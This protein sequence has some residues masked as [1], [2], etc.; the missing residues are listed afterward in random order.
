M[1]ARWK[2]GLNPDDLIARIEAGRRVTDGEITFEGWDLLNNE[3]LLLKMVDFREGVPQQEA[4]NIVQRALFKAGKKGELSR[5]TIISEINKEVNIYFQQPL[6]RFVL[7]TSLSINGNRLLPRMRFGTDQIIF[8]KLPPKFESES[9]RLKANISPVLQVIQPKD[10]MPVR[11]YLS[12]RSV[13]DA[14]NIALDRIDMIRGIWNWSINYD[15]GLRITFTGSPKPINKIILGPIHTIHRPS[16]QLCLNTNWLFEPSYIA[17]IPLYDISQKFEFIIKNTKSV[18]KKLSQ[19]Q[20]SDDII[21]G[22]QR[23]SRAL[24]EYNMNNAFLQLWSVLEMLTDTLNQ[25]YD[26]TIR[27]ASFIFKDNNYYS[28]ILEL[29]RTYRNA[30]VHHN[31]SDQDVEVLLYQL[32]RVVERIIR[33]HI[34]NKS[35]FSSVQQAGAFLSSPPDELSLKQREKRIKAALKFRGF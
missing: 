4:S 13:F 11:V 32:R 8:G 5:K 15:K 19:S 12:S 21:S 9:N 14:A 33:F 2:K 28:Q 7:V 24:D 27:R 35:Q 16:G 18:R 23:Y 10:Y 6:K 17:P 20:Y 31:D 22:L 26:V 30:F 34:N 25:S 1:S 3:T 29:L